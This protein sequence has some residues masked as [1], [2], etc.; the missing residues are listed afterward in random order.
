MPK[1][2]NNDNFIM[3]PKIDFVFKLLFGDERNKDL[4]ISFLSAVLDLPESE[5][6]GIEILNT[7]LFREFKEDKKGIL[8]VRAKTKNGKQID[9]EIQVLPTEFMPERTL[10]YWSKMYTAQVKPG[11]TYDKL[12]KCITIN[13]V[14][15]KCTPL[16]KIHSSYHLVEDETSYKL[17]D[18][19]EIHFLE[20]PKLFDE[21]ILTDEEDPIVQWMEFLDGKSKGVMEMLAKKNESI[22]KAYSLLQIISKDE[23]ARMIYEA[24][25][26]ELR[27]QLTRIKCA[28]E[29]GA[30]EKSIK[31]AQNLLRMGLSVQQVASAAEIEIDEVEMIKEDLMN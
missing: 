9:I 13:I 6:I 19:L 24:R 14:D 3:S 15:F 17:T 25:E 30:N 26:A 5:F 4:L 8:D 28:E 29:K 12:K 31:I 2:K 16:K 11:D 27:D 1:K 21:D 22:K 18:I 7:E 23:K 20:I 10:F